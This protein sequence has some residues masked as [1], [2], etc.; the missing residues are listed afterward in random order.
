MH[1]SMGMSM[2]TSRIIPHIEAG[3][4][5][6]IVVGHEDWLTNFQGIESLMALVEELNIRRVLMDFTQVELRISLTEAPDI[7]RLIDGLAPWSLDIGVMS[8]GS[9]R[10]QKTLAA[11]VSGIAACDHSASILSDDASRAEWILGVKSI[12]QAG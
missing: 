1:Q 7:V 3:Y 2:S 8:K 11:I 10:S 9:D 4:V 12:P 6:R 5:E